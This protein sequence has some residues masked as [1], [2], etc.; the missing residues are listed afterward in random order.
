MKLILAVA[1]IVAIVEFFAWIEAV[2]VVEFFAWIEAVM[3]FLSAFLFFVLFDD[4]HDDHFVFVLV[5]VFVHNPHPWFFLMAKHKI[6]S[7]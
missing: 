4:N 5:F 6:L 7:L 3:V 2:M 1:V